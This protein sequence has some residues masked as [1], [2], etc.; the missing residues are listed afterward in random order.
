MQLLDPA[1]PAG[2]GIIADPG[3]EG[4]CRLVRQL[5]LPSVNPMRVTS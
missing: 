4:A 5:L 3:V 2:L 1:F